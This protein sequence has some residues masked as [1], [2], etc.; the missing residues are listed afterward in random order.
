MSSLSNVVA[1]VDDYDDINN[2]THI[3]LHANLILQRPVTKEAQ[4]KRKTK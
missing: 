1:N 4:V 2:S 3:Y